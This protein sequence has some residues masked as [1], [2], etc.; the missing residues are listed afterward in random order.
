MKLPNGRVFSLGHLYENTGDLPN[1]A[2]HYRIAL[3]ERPGYAYALTGLARIAA[4]EKD[5]NKAILYYQQADSS[6]MDYAIKE[7]LA[8]VYRQQGNTAMATSIDKEVIAAMK[9]DAESGVTDE[10]IG[11]YV[12]RELAYAY[13]NINDVAQAE[14]HALQEYNR[15]PDN[16]DV[17]ECLA[18]VYY[19]K[20]DMDKAVTH[21]NAALATHSKN[22]TLLC[23]A[24]LIYAKAGNK[25]MAKATLQ[26][27][28]E[29]KANI[30]ES[31][32]EQ[33]THTLLAL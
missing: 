20:G 29:T 31:L 13:L 15:R 5:Y 16:I 25:T 22:P 10:S 3:Q 24:G 4:A 7:G 11:H 30:T 19:H 8:D 1:A 2:M 26:T 33:G 9:K 6:V 27:A 28:L 12:D 14:T 18:W 17:N 21:I 32:R 23:R